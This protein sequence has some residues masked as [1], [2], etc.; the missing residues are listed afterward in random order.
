[1]AVD[2]NKLAGEVC[3]LRFYRIVL[4]WDYLRLLKDFE[5]NFFSLL[6]SSLLCKPISLFYTCTTNLYVFD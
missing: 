5:V 6:F 1:M 3:T 2:K 4:S